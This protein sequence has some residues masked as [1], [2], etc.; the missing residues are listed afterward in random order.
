[1]E[2][3]RV[4]SRSA[5]PLPL[6]VSKWRLNTS[7]EAKLNMRSIALRN[8]RER[9]KFKVQEGIVRGFRLSLSKKDL[10]KYARRRSG[11]RGRREAPMSL[12][13]TIS[14]ARL[15]WHRVPSFTNR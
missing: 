14:T 10:R 13:W 2:K 4:L 8:I 3:I 7:L 5:E 11:L 1:M 12:N 6:A 9:A 15:S